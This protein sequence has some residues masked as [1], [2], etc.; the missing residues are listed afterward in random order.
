MEHRVSVVAW[1]DRELL[2][3]KVKRGAR[4][5]F[6]QVAVTLYLLYQTVSLRAVTLTERNVEPLEDGSD[7]ANPRS[8]VVER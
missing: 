1:G 6:R 3:K 8:C 7:E 4:V 2:S 5:G